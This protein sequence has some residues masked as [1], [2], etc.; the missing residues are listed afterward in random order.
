VVL[1]AVLAAVTVGAGTAALVLDRGDTTAPG[2]AEAASAVTPVLSARRLPEHVTTPGADL[3]LGL[4][5]ADL[6]ATAPADSCLAVGIDGRQILSH[7]VDRSVIPASNQKTALGSALLGVLG[8]D[9]RF[10]TEVKGAG[11]DGGGVVQGDAWL[12]GGGDPQ[13]ST[14]DYA[15]TSESQGVARSSLED[16]ADAVAGAGVTRITGR[17]VADESRYDGTRDVASWRPG[18]TRAGPLTAMSVNDGLE[19][20]PTPAD[21]TAPFAAAPDPPRTA[22]LTLA[23]LLAQRGVAVDGGVEVGPAPDQAV[24]L[25]AVESAPLGE[26]VGQMLTYSDNQT[27]EL[28]IK[29]LGVLVAGQGTTA[30]GAAALA[31]TLEEAGLDL[32]G[33]NFVDGSGLSGTNLLSCALLIATLEDAQ[34]APTLKEGMAVAGET[35]TLARSFVGTPAQGR[36]R[37]KTGS[38][39]DV[40][41]LAGYV[42]N[43]TGDELVFALV[44]NRPPFIQTSDTDLRNA[45]GLALADYPQRPPL[46]EV[47][48]VPVEP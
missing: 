37:A 25:A 40:T 7:Q 6:V 48:P 12:V 29:E 1:P 47:G 2:R 43:D 17:L 8:P 39:N 5:L 10:T 27:S 31:T 23:A 36:L 19:T 24:T 34:A 42:D 22:A 11:V 30:A 44:L 21:P 14:E 38:L 20:Y 33:T 41:S 26:I 45:V 18:G 13:L 9:H 15:A 35:G 46:A 3:T 32:A 28:L 16:L 4:R